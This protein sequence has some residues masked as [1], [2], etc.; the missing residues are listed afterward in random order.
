[1]GD[2]APA[3]LSAVRPVFPISLGKKPNEINRGPRA[4]NTY[5]GGIVG[6]AYVIR[7]AVINA[8]DWEE[9]VSADGVVSYVS[10]ITAPALREGNT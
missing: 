9:V 2:E 6:P 1:M 5:R 7:R 4:P 3:I 8:R 10:R